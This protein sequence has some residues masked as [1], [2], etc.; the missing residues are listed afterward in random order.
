MT[1]QTIELH[2]LVQMT[3]EEYHAAA[4]ISKSKLDDIAECPAKYWQR[5]ENPER[6][7]EEPTASLV[8]GDAIHTAV[9][10]P[11]SFASRYMVMPPFNLR[12]PKGREER[13]HWL[14]TEAKGARVLTVDQRDTALAAATVV[15]RHPVA[16][17]LFVG[18]VAEQSYFVRCKRT[19]A[20]KKCRLDYFH[21][22]HGLIA[23][24]KSTDD[25]SPSAFA[26]SVHNYRYHVQ[27]AWYRHE[28]LADLYGE[29]P[30]N[31]VF[32]AVEKTP[33]YVIGIYELEEEDVDRGH[34]LARRDLNTLLECRRTGF[35]PD[36]AMQPRTLA[37]PGWARHEADAALGVF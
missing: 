16:G 25:A 33:P 2:G 9:L 23:D 14:V 17:R 22:N 30:P 12:S 6:E 35:W 20:L 28:V 29:A 21:E 18:G 26:K 27:E 1:D 32:V 3:N 36:Y 13:D 7:P 15:R 34:R 24:L 4:G 31:W 37:L 8:L 10:E 11:D 19:G 5:H